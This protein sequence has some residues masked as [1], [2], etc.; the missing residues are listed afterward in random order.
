MEDDLNRRRMNFGETT[1]EKINRY[2]PYNFI[3]YFGLDIITT[4]QQTSS[5]IGMLKLESIIS[6]WK[7]I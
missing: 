3:R 7:F 2:Y 6:L 4:V 5:N 1:L